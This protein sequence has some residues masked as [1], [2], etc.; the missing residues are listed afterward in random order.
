M[1]NSV[2]TDKRILDALDLIDDKYISEV[3]AKYE[4][5]HVGGEYGM[6]KRQKVKYHLKIAALAA[7][8]CLLAVFIGYLPTILR[9]FEPFIPSGTPTA[10]PETSDAPSTEEFVIFNFASLSN[11]A[12]FCGSPYAP[13]FSVALNEDT[14]AMIISLLNKGK[15]TKGLID[16]LPDFEFKAS[17][18]G[19]EKVIRY[20]MSGGIFCFDGNCLYISYEDGLSVEAILLANV[21]PGKEFDF[22][23]LSSQAYFYN[24]FYKEMYELTVD[25]HVCNFIISVLKEL[26]WSEGAIDGIPDYI[27]LK[28][29]NGDPASIYYYSESGIFCYGSYYA[30][31]S[32]RMK[33]EINGYLNAEKEEISYPATVYIKQLV[34]DNSDPQGRFHI[35]K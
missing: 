21:T 6:P 29:G 34:A 12:E 2:F 7:A 30:Y 10:E 27:F 31:V 35:A 15:W 8:V 11:T 28:D 18:D 16:S 23:K 25:K 14:C 32:E 13:Q 22:K 26:Y 19:A 9:E 3:T 17:V 5:L 1:N 4:I 20:H 24:T 33:L